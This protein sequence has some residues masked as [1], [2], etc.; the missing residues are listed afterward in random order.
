[1]A[2]PSRNCDLAVSGPHGEP[3]L[4]VTADGPI[5]LLD[6][7]GG[8]YALVA[9]YG[10]VTRTARAVVAKDGPARRVVFAFPEEPWDGIRASP[11]EKAQAARP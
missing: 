1:M 7:P 6:A 11:E 5:C 9:T 3:L 2:R 8:D 4:H 10:G